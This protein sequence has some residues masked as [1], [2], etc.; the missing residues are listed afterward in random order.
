MFLGPKKSAQKMYLC[1]LV[2]FS[3]K[4]T[5]GLMIRSMRHIVAKVCELEKGCYNTYCSCSVTS[6][7]FCC[8]SHRP[9]VIV[10]WIKLSITCP[11][12][13]NTYAHPQPKARVAVHLRISVDTSSKE[14]KSRFGLLRR[15]SCTYVR[16]SFRYL[17]WPLS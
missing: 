5:I 14:A 6:L 3:V 17:Y 1:S 4:T 10:K 12:H 16:L 15:R 2:C 11:R 9:D 7:Q 8:E 13:H